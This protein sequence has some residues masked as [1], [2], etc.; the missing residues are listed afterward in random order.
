MSGKLLSA[1]GWELINA[2][3]FPVVVVCLL[4]LGWMVL[5]GTA[6]GGG[7]GAFGVAG[8]VSARACATSISPGKSAICPASACERVRKVSEPRSRCSSDYIFGTAKTSGQKAHVPSIIKVDQR[9]DTCNGDVRIILR[10]AV[11]FH[12]LDQIN[13]GHPFRVVL[14]Q[15]DQCYFYSGFLCRVKVDAPLDIF[16]YGVTPFGQRRD[17]LFGV[18]RIDGT[19]LCVS[20]RLCKEPRR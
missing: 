16:D 20:N 13:A 4:A 17:Y 9:L 5:R 6:R 14:C 3:V 1:S 19:F 2:L 10:E 15:N 18:G 8:A 11:A 7:V 12:S